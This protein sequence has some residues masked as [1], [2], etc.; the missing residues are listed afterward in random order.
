MN[1]D[2]SLKMLLIILILV[3][4]VAILGVSFYFYRKTK[5]YDQFNMGGRSMPMFPMILTTVGLGIGGST[6]LGYMSDAYDLGYGRIWLTASTTIT[7]VVFTAF[8]A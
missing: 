7:F 2:P 3:Y 4:L 5:T 8:L 1:I 6:L